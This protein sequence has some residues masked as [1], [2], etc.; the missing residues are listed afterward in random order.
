MGS[1]GQE[2]ATPRGCKLPGGW[3]GKAV[4]DLD[5]FVRGHLLCDIGQFGNGLKW[6]LAICMLLR[7]KK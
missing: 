6:Y 1:V 2:E 4:N 7:L 3:T 5:K